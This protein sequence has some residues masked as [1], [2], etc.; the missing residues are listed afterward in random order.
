MNAL[1]LLLVLLAQ[2]TGGGAAPLLEKGERLFRQGDTAGALAAFQEAAKA[3]PRDAR[4]QYL[5]GVALEKKAHAAGRDRRLPQGDRRSSRD[6]PRRTTTSAALL[7]ARGDA[8]GAAPELE[9][10]LRT[11]PDFAEAAYNLGVARDA[12]GKNG[13]AVAAYRHRRSPQALRRRLPAEPGRRASPAP[14]ICPG[15]VAALKDATRLAPRNPVAWADLG[16]VLSDQKDLDGAQAALDKATKLKPDFALAWNRLGRVELRSGSS[17]RRRGR[18]PGAGP[19]AGRQERRLRRRSLPRVAGT[20]GRRPRRR[21]VP[22]R[23]RARPQEP[24]RALR[25]DEGPGRQGGLPRRQVRAGRF[26]GASRA[27][28]PRRRSRPTPSSPPAPN[29]ALTEAGNLRQTPPET[30]QIALPHRRSF[31]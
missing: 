27:S 24:A 10:A 21:R 12:L 25:A 20:E 15:A 3:D 11:K 4:P 8:A 18:G 6:F 26:K 31:G 14:A 2:E 5:T 16:M 9:A 23:R 1:P 22:R 30:G 19:Q 17:F 13:E 28:S 7:I 29:T